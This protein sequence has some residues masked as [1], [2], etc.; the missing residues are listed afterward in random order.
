MRLKT[1]ILVI[2]IVALVIIGAWACY[3]YFRRSQLREELLRRFSK[4]R[5]EYQK[6]R[7]QGY[8]VSEVGRWMEKARDA[9]KKGDYE[10][11]VKS[12]GKRG[13]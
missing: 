1:L 9:F 13:V 6:K 3:V 10:T 5:A 8:N 11:V 7:A 2:S 4:L 12:A